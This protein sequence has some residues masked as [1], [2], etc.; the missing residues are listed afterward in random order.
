MEPLLNVLKNAVRRGAPDD[1]REL[2]A[3]LGVLT[4]S[5]PTHAILLF[6]IVALAELTNLHGRGRRSV[7][8]RQEPNR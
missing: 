1:I 4:F 2:A 5:K 6:P 3:V 8:A 7:S